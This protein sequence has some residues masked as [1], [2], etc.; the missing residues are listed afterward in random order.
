MSYLITLRLHVKPFIEYGEVER[1]YAG[2]LGVFHLEDLEAKG[3]RI[4]SPAIRYFMG[5]EGLQ[6]IQ[7]G[8]CE[9]QNLVLIL[10]K[11]R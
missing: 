2:F 9:I 6:F 1:Y 5:A 8:N 3:S 10:F 4:S 7:E 11:L